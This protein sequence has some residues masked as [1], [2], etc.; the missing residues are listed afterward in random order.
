M[1]CDPCIGVLQH[2]HNFINVTRPGDPRYDPDYGP[3][4]TVSTF[5]EVTHKYIKQT[6]LTYTHKFGHHTTCASLATSA[7]HGCCICQRVWNVLSSDEQESLRTADPRKGEA[8]PTGTPALAFVTNAELRQWVLPNTFDLAIRYNHKVCAGISKHAQFILE[9]DESKSCHSR[10]CACADHR[11]GRTP[12]QISDV[13]IAFTSDRTSSIESMQTAAKW[14]QECVSSHL[15]CNT[16]ERNPVWYPTRLLRLAHSCEDESYV[17][18][19]HTAQEP[20]IGPYSTLSHCW[21]NIMPAQLTRAM[22]SESDP[23]FSVVNLPKTFQE[24]IEVSKRLNIWYLWID[25]LCIIQSGDDRQ[26]WYREASLMEKVYMHSHCN[27]SATD[28]DDGTKGLFR[29]RTPQYIGRP[30]VRVNLEG[31]GSKT[32]HME[33]LVT[34]RSLWEDALDS[35]IDKRGWVFQERYLAPRVLH[36]CRDQL[37][38]ECKELAACETFSRGLPLMTLFSTSAWLKYNEQNE[39]RIT[40]RMVNSTDTFSEDPWNK[41]VWTYTRKSLSVSGDKLVALS[42]VAKHMMSHVRD[43]YIVGMWRR[44]LEK[45]LMWEVLEIR[46]RPP[47]YRAP[48]WSWASVDGPIWYVSRAAQQSLTHIEDVVLDYATEDTTG[49]VTG[50]WLDLSGHLRPMRLKGIKRDSGIDWYMVVGGGIVSKHDANDT[51]EELFARLDTLYGEE[52]AFDNDNKEKRLFFMP[53]LVERSDRNHEVRCLLLRLTNS[54]S[55]IF[56][57]IGCV[58][59]YSVHEE[60]VLLAELDEETKAGLP[61]LRYENGLHTIRII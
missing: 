17:R 23:R 50:G 29:H 60:D 3:D 33:C 58:D 27:I 22:A 49:A 2:R 44:D 30:R 37:F 34:N 48:S 46:P 51:H 26:D 31:I 40:E 39:R 18:L 20:P 28:A 9:P 41:L 54:K 24:A 8:S 57:R 56:E 35:P 5:S 14:L 11:T 1:F 4:Y 61:C 19:I 47:G 52:E 59:S 10:I 15:I 12:S 21:G 55:K 36:F 43:I 7:N 16:P 6:W 32:E 42:G 53:G 38:W 25:S 13:Q 45:K